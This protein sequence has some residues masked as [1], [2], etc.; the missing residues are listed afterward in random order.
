MPRNVEIKAR[1]RDP[2]AVAAVAAE[3]ADGPVAVLEQHDIFYRSD[4]GRLKLRRFPD[5]RGE[6][7]AYSRPDQPGPKTSRYAIHRTDDGDGLAATL[8]AGLA[9]IGE[10]IKTRRLYL[11]GRTRVHLDAV[12]GLG[13]FLELEVVLDEGEGVA[14]GEAEAQR[15]LAALGVAHGDLVAGAYVDLLAEGGGNR[16]A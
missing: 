13:S 9:P 3:L 16:M 5:G 4:E 8:A 14:A 11:V 15:L 12:D 2:D 1:L 6:L 7:I 10:V